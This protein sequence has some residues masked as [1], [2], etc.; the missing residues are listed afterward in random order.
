MA[1]TAQEKAAAAAA[2]AADDSRAEHAR[3]EERVLME[4]PELP[5]TQVPGGRVE[6]SRRQL[7]VVY[8]PSGWV[9]VKPEDDPVSAAA[10][11]APGPATA[12]PAPAG[13]TPKTRS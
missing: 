4:H 11:P 12:P 3:L 6:M 5:A 13:D 9:E 8:G 7:E 2:T 1:Q 10:I